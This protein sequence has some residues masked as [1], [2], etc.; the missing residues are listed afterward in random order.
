MSLKDTVYGVVCGFIAYFVVATCT[1]VSVLFL[2][3]LQ[4][5]SCVVF[6]LMSS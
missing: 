1:L 2:I 3:I 5:L 6:V 4:L